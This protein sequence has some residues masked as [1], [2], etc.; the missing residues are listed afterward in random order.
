[1]PDHP[2]PDPR[3]LVQQLSD[4]TNTSVEPA[5]LVQLLRP[6]RLALR[7]SPHFSRALYGQTDGFWNALAAVWRMQAERLENG[8]KSSIP[9]VLALSAFLVSLCTQEP[10]NQREAV[11]HVEPHLR[12]VLV[13]VSSLFNLEDAAYTDITRTCCQ[14]LANLITGNEAL[15]STYFPRRLEL[16]AEDHLIQRL[17]ASPDHT[18]LQAVV[19]FLLNSIYGSRERALLLGT[20]KTGSAILDRLMVLVSALFGDESPDHIAN[21]DYTSDVFALA[22][23]TVQQI[24]SLGAFAETY[25]AHALMPGFAIS[26][27]LVTLLK[28]LDGHLSSSLSPSPSLSSSLATAL[29]L[30]PFLL[31]QLNTLSSSLLTTGKEGER[32][33]DA[34]DAATF[35][36]AVLVL[37]CLCEVGLGIERA[38]Q[39]GGKGSVSRGGLADGVDDVVRLLQFASTLSPAPAPR[40]PP[41]SSSSSA[42]IT[43]IPPSS[44]A[45]PPSTSPSVSTSAEAD[46]PA[47]EQLKRT[48]VRYLG[49]VSFV[50]AHGKSDV[51]T[52]RAQARV[53]ESGGLALLLGMCQIDERNP[54]LREHALFAIRN[55]LKGNQENQEFVEG[56]K[57]QF[58]V[59]P[60]G[61]LQDLP[62]A[63]RKS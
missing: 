11:T 15:A 4:Y 5:E 27:T 35:Q 28:F 12:K 16:E 13:V 30:V 36:G 39:E 60:D 33:K 18:T 25:E 63:L 34:A 19:I 59:G 26:P 9:A 6:P 40:P 1:M 23:A 57:P 51:E 14:A 24:I 52:K 8:D 38:V 53:R 56:I 61:A 3:E 58:V 46:S 17:L 32:A 48:C 45:S 54:T 43:E 44:P 62:P 31:R 21:E 37:H 47:I 22:F 7:S 41:S 10:H 20:S 2:P 55:V 50:P 42:T 49:I 29:S